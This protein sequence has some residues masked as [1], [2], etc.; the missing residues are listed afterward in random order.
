MFLILFILFIIWIVMSIYWYPIEMILINDDQLN[1]GKISVNHVHGIPNDV[2]M[3]NTSLFGKYIAK[4]YYWNIKGNIYDEMLLSI[5]V[6][7]DPSRFNYLEQIINKFEGPVSVSIYIENEMNDLKLVNDL[8][9]KLASKER[10]YNISFGLII[11]NKTLDICQ[12]S[13]LEKRD[14]IPINALRNLAIYQVN[15]SYVVYL[16][17]DFTQFSNELKYFNKNYINNSNFLD[18]FQIQKFPRHYYKQQKNKQRIQK[19]YDPQKFVFILPS[20]Q[21][22]NSTIESK[23]SHPIDTKSAL[24]KHINLNH[25]EMFTKHWWRAQICTNYNKWYNTSNLYEIKL[26]NEYYEPYFIIKT[27]WYH[28]YPFNPTFIGR[29]A[30]KVSHIITLFHNC[31]QFY[32]L[33]TTFI[34]H[35][36][37]SHQ[38]I[39]QKYNQSCI[40]LKM[41][42]NYKCIYANMCSS[43]KTCLGICSHKKMKKY[44]QYC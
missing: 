17:V 10:K 4:P 26:S 25:I 39:K 13:I 7:S 27:Q 5:A 37:L 11:G 24:L 19:P 28:S 42:S 41:E 3:V 6:V 36:G 18:Q 34:I 30:N 43:N 16:D 21:F 23:I 32:V 15:T 29:G 20:F 12:D 1:D 8:Y 9:Y 35:V 33:P 44:L 2:S 31:F 22:V 40:Q 38:N 14:R